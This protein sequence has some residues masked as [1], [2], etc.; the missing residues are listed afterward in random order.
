MF[1]WHS[2]A[3]LF[4]SSEASRVHI[5]CVVCV[6]CETQVDVVFWFMLSRSTSCCVR[7]VHALVV[8]AKSALCHDRSVSTDR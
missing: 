4:Q 5:C 6:S 2:V 3:H 1:C 8:D 7:L